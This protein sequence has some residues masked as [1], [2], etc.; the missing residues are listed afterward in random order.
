MKWNL[1]YDFNTNTG[2]GSSY[3]DDDVD[4]KSGT[5]ES[6]N[7]SDKEI[8]INGGKKVTVGELLA[9]VDSLNIK[10][11][12]KS[13]W[14]HYSTSTD[15]VLS[16]KIDELI[17]ASQEYG[18]SSSVSVMNVFTR[19]LKRME[20]LKGRLDVCDKIEDGITSIIKL[21]EDKIRLFLDLKESLSRGLVGKVRKY[22]G[23]KV[24]E[25]KDAIHDRAGETI[26][27]TVLT[28]TVAGT[29]S[30]AVMPFLGSAVL[31]AATTPVIALPT[32]GVLATAKVVQSGYSAFKNFKT[33]RDTEQNIDLLTN[34]KDMVIA[35]KTRTQAEIADLYDKQREKYTYEFETQDKLRQAFLSVSPD[36]LS[37]LDIVLSAEGPSSQKLKDIKNL[38]QKRNLPKYQESILLDAVD[39]LSGRRNEKSL[40]FS[41]ALLSDG[42]YRSE[43]G[44]K[45]L[46]SDIGQ[47]KEYA[48]GKTFKMND[49]DD[50][51]VVSTFTNN[52]IKF[53]RIEPNGNVTDVEI[54]YINDKENKSNSGY[55]Y[56]ELKDNK[57]KLDDNFAL[58]RLKDITTN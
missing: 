4:N 9:S 45:S 58:K 34:L 48:V 24:E 33:R 14:S 28:S 18:I 49:K 46:L 40:N 37:Q 13:M 47:I 31:T 19:S 29:A 53:K 39:I 52:G 12:A 8:D 56:I 10:E 21:N 11:R 16:R 30:Y 15:S 22:A 7:I 36:I 6:Q 51:F 55:F 1:C 44:F 43:A 41:E 23:D 38:I 42:E 54:K 25:F 26:T 5:N 57:V 35:V 3:E 20:Y 27:K 17:N 2:G 32:V 50:R